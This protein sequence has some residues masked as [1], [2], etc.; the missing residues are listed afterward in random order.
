MR[1]AVVL[2]CASLAC[3]QHVAY[4]QNGQ[5]WIKA[6]DSDAPRVVSN[7]VAPH[8]LSFSPDGVWLAF[9]DGDVL[10][11]VATSGGEIQHPVGA[12]PAGGFQWSAAGIL[13]MSTEDGVFTASA[14]SAWRP[15]RVVASDF[16]FLL[17]RDG[18]ERVVSV[19]DS[20]AEGM[21]RSSHLEIMPADGR[22]P[23]RRIFTAGEWEEIILL[24]WIGDS[25]I[26]WKGDFSGS[27][28]CDGFELWAFSAAGAP[29][30]KLSDGT[31][32]NRDLHAF[33]PDGKQLAVTNGDG[34]EAWTHKN[35][36]VIDVESG[37]SRLISASGAAA[38][39][40]AWS[41]KGD[42]IA[43][44]SGPDVGAVGGGDPAKD[45]LDAR[46]LWVANA[47]GSTPRQLTSN[48]DFRDERPI[49]SPDGKSL[50]FPRISRDDHASLWTI[51]AGGGDPK[52]LVDRIDLDSDVT[53]FGYYGYIDWSERV[54]I[55]LK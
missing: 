22:G 15:S 37:R 18:T 43:F 38:L 24:A 4:V 42:A 3:A 10:S 27:G 8:N 2:A 20:G 11:V 47:D 44:I 16:E 30:R 52:L 25:I 39:F 7:I 1:T 48:P 5:L 55:S 40:P 29:P 36:T 41:P 45:A 23:A 32:L 9:L 49:W 13:E 53:W 33:S 46:R 28:A 19:I 14:V 34:R 21:P 12:Q 17:S 35:I 54:A 26:G 50:V 31:L 51:P 6:L